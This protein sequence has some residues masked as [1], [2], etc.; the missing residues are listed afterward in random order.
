MQVAFA[1]VMSDLSDGSFALQIGKSIFYLDACMQ[2][3]AAVAVALD[4]IHNPPSS[5]LDRHRLPPV[6]PAQVLGQG[7]LL[8]GAAVSPLRGQPQR[9]PRPGQARGAVSGLL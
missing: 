8:Q 1:L 2:L 7:L 4:I 6:Q 3:V 9:Q 5:H